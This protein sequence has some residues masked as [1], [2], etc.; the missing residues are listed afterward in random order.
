M[1]A[2][3]RKRS[4]RS[5][6]ASMKP[7]RCR[8]LACGRGFAQRARRRQRER[9]PDAGQR[10]TIDLRSGADSLNLFGSGNVATVV[11]VENLVAGP[12]DDV[13]TFVIPDG[14]VNQTI[15]LGDGTNVLN[16][17]GTASIGGY[18]LTLS[19]MNPTVFG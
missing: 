18:S 1:G 12:G 8:A 19:G 15:N 13:I 5:C 3:G 16:L 17:G 10:H 11:S 9:V 2:F 4:M 7:P 6:S 14:S